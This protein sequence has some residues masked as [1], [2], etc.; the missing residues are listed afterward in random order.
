MWHSDLAYRPRGSIGSMLFAVEIPDEGGNTGFRNMYAAYDM[1]PRHLKDALEGK[2]AIFLAGRNNSKRPFIKRLNP[3]QTKRN[4]AVTH[5]A[6]RVHPESGRR[7]IFVNPQH[8][9]AIE[10]MAES[11]SDALLAE[12][13]AH[14]DRPEFAYS[15]RWRVGDLTFWDNRCVQHIADHSRLDDPAYIRHMHRTTIDGEAIF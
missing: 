12:V 10:G 3:A 1:L 4:P 15:H 13:Y 6:I 8:T 14:C 9:V 2:R 11:E 5:P 7:A